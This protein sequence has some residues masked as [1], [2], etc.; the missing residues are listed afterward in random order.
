MTENLACVTDPL[1]EVCDQKRFDVSSRVYSLSETCDRTFQGVD[2]ID[3]T[4]RSH[5][6]Y[7]RSHISVTLRKV[8]VTLFGRRFGHTT[9]SAGELFGSS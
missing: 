2:S 9:F 4:V 7:F 3:S 1:T 8:S 5:T 6:R